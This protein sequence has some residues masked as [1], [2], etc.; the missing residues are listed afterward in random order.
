MSGVAQKVV[1]A[2]DRQPAGAASAF[3][4]LR[5]GKRVWA[6]GAVHGGVAHLRALHAAIGPKLADGDRLVYL[7]NLMGYGPDVIATIDEALRFRR[8]F[9][10]RPRAF[11]HDMA[12]LRGCQEEMWQKLLELQFSVNPGEVLQWMIDHGV[13]ATIEA[14]GGKPKTGFSAARQGALALSRWIQELRVALRTHAGHQDYLS[15]LRRY[16]RSHDE[17]ILCVS[18]G[19]DPRAPLEA[20]D[21]ALWW[22]A[23]GF[24]RMVAPFGGFGVVVR[25][26]DPARRGIVERGFAVSVDASTEFGQGIAAVCLAAGGEIVE[27]IVA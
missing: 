26:F 2:A 11:P 14:Y 4:T 23:Q 13:G 9:L 6:I 25:G 12:F 3:T 22:N 24:D 20:Q 27:R 8:V 16:A 15:A 1:A 19:I 21:D 18:A 10:A 17:T 7:G 5:P